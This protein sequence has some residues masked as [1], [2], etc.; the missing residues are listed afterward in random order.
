MGS[1][2]LLGV[3]SCHLSVV[4]VVAIVVAA[5]AA[6]FSLPN[7]SRFCAIEFAEFE[8]IFSNEYKW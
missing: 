4:V 1:M 5:A 2:R 8:C 7:S 3:S 6:V